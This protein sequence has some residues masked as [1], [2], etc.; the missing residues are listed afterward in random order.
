MHTEVPHNAPGAQRKP[1]QCIC[2]F[3]MVAAYEYDHENGLCGVCHD[4]LI[5]LEV[6]DD[7]QVRG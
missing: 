4:A 1:H 5:H 6:S 7:Y 2:C 3:L